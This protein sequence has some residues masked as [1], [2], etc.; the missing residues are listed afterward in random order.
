MVVARIDTLSS[1]LL[2]MSGADNEWL[3]R[4]A[5]LDRPEWSSVRVLAA[6]I[7]DL[8]RGLGCMS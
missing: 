4:P 2:A 1:T 5:A 3:W 6:E 7:L 8:L